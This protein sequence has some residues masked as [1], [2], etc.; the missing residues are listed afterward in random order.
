MHRAFIWAATPLLWSVF[1]HSTGAQQLLKPQ[2]IRFDGAPQY[3]TDELLT[4]VGVK[5]GQVYT[6]DYFNQ[7]AQKLM[8]T[9]VFD[10][11]GFKFDG[12]DLVYTIHE[13]PNLYQVTIGNIPI[14]TGAELDAHLHQVIPLYHGKVPSEGTLFDD[15]RSALQGMVDAE[16]IDAKVAMV[17][18]GENS[19]KK[20]TALKFNIGKAQVELGDIEITGV[21]ESLRKLVDEA[22]KRVNKG[23]DATNSA[24]I[25]VDQIAFAYV[26]Q[27]FPSAVIQAHPS[28][29]PVIENGIIRVP[30]AVTVQEGRAYKLGTVK[31][32][33]NI[34]IAV[35]D[36]EK[37]TKP[38]DR[39]TPEFEYV[40]GLRGAIEARLKGKGYLDCKVKTDPE[41]D[42][43]A[44][45]VNYTVDAV[46]G[47][48]Y[49]L[50]LIKFDNVSDSMRSL[51][52]RNW[53]MMPGDP[54]DESYVSNF[55]L[56]AQKSDPVLQRSLAGVAATYDA[57][58]N[59]ETHEVNLVIRLQRQ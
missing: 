53:Q 37:M 39:Y 48:Q 59:S 54:F 16:G 41:I 52:M 14:E 10:N 8:A 57:H 32:A 47:E 12:L 27:G 38:R 19:G 33:S 3:S 40:I 21:S 11:V 4:V 36:L 2:T 26:G 51:L 13:N 22:L 25:L 49:H 15:V 45:T 18:A 35:S 58:A 6:A 29:K 34:P 31:L 17:P 7:T 5:K 46:P 55:I 50:G 23:F 44:G 30:F 9:G 20:A 28:G 42:E 56:L 43:T 1:A 24:S